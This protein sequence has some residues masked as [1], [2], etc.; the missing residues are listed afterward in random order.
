MAVWCPGRCH[1]DLMFSTIRAWGYAIVCRVLALESVLYDREGQNRV[2]VCVRSR[3]FAFVCV[4]MVRMLW[5]AVEGSSPVTHKLSF[6]WFYNNTPQHSSSR[7]CSS[8]ELNDCKICWRILLAW[9]VRAGGTQR[10]VL[11]KV[12]APY[13]GVAY[14]RY[15]LACFLWLVWIF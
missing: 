1:L 15:C 9:T 13:R 8:E 5:V 3:S 10:Y 4:P 2:F 11:L 7:C 6:C 12:P 14:C